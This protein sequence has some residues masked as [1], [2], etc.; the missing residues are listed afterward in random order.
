MTSENLALDLL[1]TGKCSQTENVNAEEATTRAIKIFSLAAQNN[2]QTLLETLQ[3]VIEVK[4][5]GLTMLALA[6]LA[7]QASEN[8]LQKNNTYSTFVMFFSVYGPPKILEFVE[9]SKSKYFGRG[10]GSRPQKW[11]RAAMESWSLNTLQK[12]SVNHPKKLY[13]L[14]ML[15]HPRYHGRKGDFIRNFLENSDKK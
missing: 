9:Y 6:I 8:F 4:I 15:I 3:E 2:P 11:V 7:S 12:F 1:V 13:S 10:L 14:I 5:D